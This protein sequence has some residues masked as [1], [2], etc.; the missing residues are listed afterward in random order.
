MKK[1][2]QNFLEKINEIKPAVMFLSTFFV[3]LILIFISTFKFPDSGF[4][5]FGAGLLPMVLYW[6][7]AYSFNGK[8]NLSMVADGAYFLGFLFTLCS[9]SMALYN[10]SE[11][12]QGDLEIGKIIKIFG[13]ALVT[14]IV[15]LLIKISL[16][17]LQPAF[18]D[19]IEN[20]NNNLMSTVGQFDAQLAASLDVF[21]AFQ[22]RMDEQLQN[23]LDRYKKFEERM[24]KMEEDAF[25]KTGERID[26]ILT[27]SSQKLEGFIEESGN[28]LS[29]SLTE[30]SRN[31][32]NAIDKV[33][34]ELYIPSD[35]FTTKLEEPL[36]NMRDQ[37]INFNTELEEVI[38]S[39]KTISSNTSKASDIVAKLVEKM[40]L[41]DKIPDLAASIDNSINEI[42]LITDTFKDTGKKINEIT[43]SFDQVIEGQKEKLEESNQMTAQ[44]KENLEFFKNYNKQIKNNLSKSKEYMEMLQ[45]EL[46]SAADLIIKKLG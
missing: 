2:N 19:V 4:A 28:S 38:K 16:V 30:S 35:L 32:S 3:G 17:H 1:R 5:I 42:N 46:S 20:V 45:K 8:S 11:S 37:I 7:Y 39:Q 15:G 10:Y 23:S 25:E 34:E 31:L 12:I 26:I 14:T 22:Q 24:F 9:I 18:D 41:G 27:Q 6:V 44:M 29:N 43:E 33:A 36:S 40:D 13:F 21:I